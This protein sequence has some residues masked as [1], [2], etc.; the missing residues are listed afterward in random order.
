MVYLEWITISKAECLRPEEQSADA[1]N[2]W[3]FRVRL[4]GVYFVSLLM[5]EEHIAVSGKFQSDS[6]IRT[7]CSPS[8]HVNNWLGCS[9]TAAG[10]RLKFDPSTPIFMIFGR[11]LQLDGRH[12][13][14][15][16]S[17]WA[18]EAMTNFQSRSN[19]VPALQSSFLSKKQAYTMWPNSKSHLDIIS[20]ELHLVHL[21]H[22][23]GGENAIF[24]Q[25]VQTDWPSWVWKETMTTI[26]VSAERTATMMIQIHKL[27][28]AEM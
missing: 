1:A 15:F 28:D 24:F 13:S 7:N 27:V 12:C 22:V 6:D 17:Y 8:K 10:K 18:Y 14:V 9:S 4:W 25:A 5:Q 21:H 20:R 3:S 23:L 2:T 16:W 26:Y 11:R 19:C